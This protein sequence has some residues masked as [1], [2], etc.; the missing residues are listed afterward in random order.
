MRLSAYIL[1]TL[2]LIGPSLSSQSLEDIFADVDTLFMAGAALGHLAPMDNTVTPIVTSSLCAAPQFNYAVATE[3][4]NGRIIAVA[5]ESILGNG[6]IENNDNLTFLLN[7]CEWL[8]QG[9]KRIKLKQGWINNSNVSTLQAA[10]IQQD[11]LFSTINGDITEA[12]LSDTDVLILGNDWNGEQPYSDSALSELRNFVTEGGAILIA[13][14]GWSWPQSLDLYPMNAVAN[15]FGF[16]Y[17]RD[18]LS[19]P[20]FNQNGSPKLHNFY[21]ENLDTNQTPYCPSPYLG[22]NFSRGENLRVMRLAVSTTGEFTQQNGGVAETEALISQ[23]LET[24]NLIYGR[25]YCVRFELIDNNSELIFPDPATD[26]WATLPAGSGGCQNANLI[27]SQQGPVIDGLIGSNNYDISHVIAG[28]PFGGG[29][30]GG[31]K[32]ALS[33]G[34]DI[35][36]TRHELGHQFTQA[37]TINHPNNSNYEPENG[38]WTIQGGNAQGHGHAVSFHELADFLEN[39]ISHIG[40]TVPTNNSIPTV[41]AGPN[42]VIP[43]STPFTLTAS[44]TDAD[45]ED[46]LTYVWDNMNPALPHRLPVS[47]DSQG[48]IFMRLLPDTSVS[49]TFPRISDVIANNNSNNQE[50]L[51]TTPRIMDI[52]LTVNDNHKIMHQGRSIYASATNS[53]DLQITVAA[54]GPFEVTSQNFSDLVYSGGSLQ[55]VTWNVNGTDTAPINTQFV[56]ISLSTDG[57]LTYSSSLAENIPNVGIAIVTIPNINTNNARIKVEAVDNIYFDINTED[58]EIAMTSS[59][60]ET[61]LDQKI[62]I[63]PNPA[64][65]FIEILAPENLDLNIKLLGIDGTIIKSQLQDRRIDISGNS[66]G[67]YLV[68]ITNLSTNTSINKKVIIE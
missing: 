21:P 33:G 68:Q 40:T 11:F 66:P 12:A 24:I 10:L 39:F 50:Q 25:E 38:A 47:D 16:E 53:D 27:L 32:T 52:R 58:F 45:S 43:I 46:R 63:S 35:P 48:A 54:A 29:C 23:W 5:H 4:E 9:S 62:T 2:L 37:H 64:R 8:N 18:V 13:G 7:S 67:L 15:L 42:R 57:G 56:T 17:T 55:E 19:D 41:D 22:K 51:P 14:L 28:R 65:D 60:A 3:Y 20:T 1:S 34:L 49:R 44:A 59:V 6:N 61:E 26:P 30:A 31:L 36:V